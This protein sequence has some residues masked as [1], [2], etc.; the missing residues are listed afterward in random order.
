MSSDNPVT[1][2]KPLPDELRGWNWGAFLLNWVWGLAHNTWIALLMFVPGVN[3]VMPFV[4]GAKGNQ[5]AWE[6]NTWESVEDFKR[7]QRIWARVGV[8][9]A[10]GIPA[11]FGLVFWGVISIINS[12]DAYQT[13]Q[14]ELRFH[15]ALEKSLGHPVEPA[16]WLTLGNINIQNSTGWADLEFAVKGPRGSGDAALYLELSDDVWRIKEAR[17]VTEYGED[18]E[19]VE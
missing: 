16:G 5:W 14:D 19:L 7:H 13:A 1:R 8:G 10:I 4:L 6:N 15:P 17:V 18:I 3:L 12:S 9:A 2:P 11:F